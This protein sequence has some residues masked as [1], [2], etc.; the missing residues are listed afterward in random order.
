ML[1]HEATKR[2]LKVFRK[3]DKDL[4]KDEITA[5]ICHQFDMHAYNRLLDVWQMYVTT[6]NNNKIAYVANGLERYN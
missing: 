4:M 1:V 5:C 6:L 2:Y 3:K